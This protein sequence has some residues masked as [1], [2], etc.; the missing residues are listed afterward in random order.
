[1][2]TN[3]QMLFYFIRFCILPNIVMLIK[4]S[5]ELAHIK[6]LLLI[7]HVQVA[8]NSTDAHTQNSTLTEGNYISQ[9]TAL[10]KFTLKDIS[11]LCQFVAVLSSPLRA[12]HTKQISTCSYMHFETTQE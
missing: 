3:T 7:L 6:T 4:M 8:R 1:M 12:G 9:L 2:K 11:P 10:T 5:P